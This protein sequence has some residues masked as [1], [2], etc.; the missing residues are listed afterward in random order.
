MEKCVIWTRRGWKASNNNPLYQREVCWS[1]KQNKVARNA[2][3]SVNEIPQIIMLDNQGYLRMVYAPFQ[4]Y[5]FE[6]V[7]SLS[8][9]FGVE[10]QLKLLLL[11]YQRSYEPIESWSDC[12]R[13][14][15]WGHLR[16]EPQVSYFMKSW[17]KEETGEGSETEVAGSQEARKETNGDWLNR[18]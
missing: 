9:T 17:R 14:T 2:N 3:V 15:K 18:C 10:I 13:A 7:E 11:I 1:L 16:I 4:M 6:F 8:P 12:A 5:R